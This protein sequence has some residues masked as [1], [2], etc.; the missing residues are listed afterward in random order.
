[1]AGAGRQE[2]H[3]ETGPGLVSGAQIAGNNEKGHRVHQLQGRRLLARQILGSLPSRVCVQRKVLFKPQFTS[4]V[5]LRSQQGP[6]ESWKEHRKTGV[7]ATARRWQVLVKWAS[8]PSRRLCL[9]L[10]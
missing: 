5:S 1:M 10:G 2:R 3:Q 4:P 9:S 7:G 8:V 6:S